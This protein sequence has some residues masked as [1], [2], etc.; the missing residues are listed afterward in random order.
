MGIK[1]IE[2]HRRE[3]VAMEAMLDE[4]IETLTAQI[5]DFTKKI[6]DMDVELSKIAA[7][8][9]ISMEEMEM[10]M[11]HDF[12][13]KIKQIK[14]NNEQ[15]L[16]ERDLAA[17]K[18]NHEK[19]DLLTDLDNLKDEHE[20]DLL[21]KN[22]ENNETLKDAV[23][24]EN[25]KWRNKMADLE[26]EAR[27]MEKRLQDDITDLEMKLRYEILESDGKWKLKLQQKQIE[28][29]L[30]ETR[31]NKQIAEAKEQAKDLKAEMRQRSVDNR[32][33]LK[34]KL[35]E[36]VMEMKENHQKNVEEAVKKEIKSLK[37]QMEQ[38]AKKHF[39]EMEK[40]EIE[41]ATKEDALS[42]ILARKIDLIKNCMK[43]IEQ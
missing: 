3:K 34:I 31:L 35:N 12:E 14:E 32:N 37:N 19:N 24:E 10:T 13:D 15:E 38:Q 36:K 8:H 30:M 2:D 25:E 41:I 28:K 7:E 5:G 20:N 11:N 22:H 33:D 29:D 43:W 9:K 21:Q 23:Y 6:G 1:A 40:N 4:K 39:F 42:R 16:T 27:N 26:R 18:L 17:S